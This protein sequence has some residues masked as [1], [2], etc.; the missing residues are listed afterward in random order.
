MFFMI[1]G[2]ILPMAIIENINANQN[3]DFKQNSVWYYAVSHKKT[4]LY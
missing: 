1:Y 4:C 3:V 2:H